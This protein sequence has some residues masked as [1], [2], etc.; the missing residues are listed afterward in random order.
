MTRVRSKLRRTSLERLGIVPRG[1]LREALRP[2]VTWGEVLVAGVFVLAVVAV[3]NYA[4]LMKLVRGRASAGNLQMLGG[5]V[6][7]VAALVAMGLVYLER[8]QRKFVRTRQQLIVFGSC[9]LAVVLAGKV[10][11]SLDAVLAPERWLGLAY[12][13]PLSAFS[14]LFAVIYGQRE[15]IAASIM[16]AVL[17]GLA[18]QTDPGNRGSSGEALPA[19]VVLLSGALLA[20]LAS[21][22]IR[23]RLRLLKV[24]VAVGLVHVAL[25]V[26]F[27]L[28]RGEVRLD[29]PPTELLWGAANGVGVGILMTVSLPLVELIFNVATDIRLLEL[30]DQ[31][32]PLLRYLVTL[33]P[34]TDNHSRRMALLS[35]AAAEAIGANSLLALVGSYYHD[36]GKMAKP[37]YFIEN[38][39]GTESPHD[40]LRPSL[41]A[42]IIASHTKDGVELGEECGLPPA[43]IDLIAQ[44]HGTS[45]IEFFYNRYL[46][47]ARDKPLLE[48]NFFRYPGPKPATREA[49]IVLLADAVEAASRTLAEPLPSRIETLIKKI[50]TAKF[51]D[52]QL[53]ECGLTLS[54]L[55]RIEHSFFRVLCSMHH[56]RID[57]PTAPFG[58]G[59]RDRGAR[60]VAPVA[61]S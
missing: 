3:L 10:L 46:E 34:S 44:H 4:A 12:L 43:I 42:L 24:G 16:L 11:V 36:I 60:R 6:V 48:A 50:T 51:L 53:E 40:R 8:F 5:S 15:A 27:K 38:Q 54:E 61:S 1:R 13:V 19:V 22:K 32:Q 20:A 58:R 39:T 45:I 33:A 18:L 35:E 14:I 30:S 37:G 29:N 17:V 25:M 21:R 56:A 2:G 49:A 31:E 59:P 9:C 7:V 52:G 41:S 28:L 26:G 23:S 47:D 57:Y 55:H